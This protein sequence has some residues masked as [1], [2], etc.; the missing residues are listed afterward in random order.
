MPLLFTDA[1]AQ[2]ATALLGNIN[3]L[4]LDYV[5]RQKVAS[6]NM[7][8]FYYSTISVLPPGAYS[9]AD[10]LFIVPRVLELHQRPGT[11]NRSPTMSG[12]TPIPKCAP[13]I[14]LQWLENIE[15]TSGHS[16]IS[17]GTVH[18]RG[19]R[20]LPALAVSLE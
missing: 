16:D 7:S 12:V 15:R 9:P 3:S 6:M 19:E 8:F 18:A 4:A 14:E 5:A 1:G 13:L 2:H 10:L 11:F 20:L 17:G